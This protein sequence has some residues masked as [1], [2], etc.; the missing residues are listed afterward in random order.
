M[1]AIGL[2]AAAFL[3]VG[4]VQV[5]DFVCDDAFISFRY[6]ANLVEHGELVF[7]VGERVEGYSNFL[8]TVAMALLLWLDL[9]PV[10]GSQVAGLA[11]S[12][13][14]LAVTAAFHRRLDRPGSRRTSGWDA[15]APLLL[16]SSSAFA[17]WTSGGLETALFTL[18]LTLASMTLWAARHDGE[19]R[20]AGWGGVWAG[21]AA[22][23]RPEGVLFAAAATLWSLIG[24][25]RG[26]DRE[27]S[28]AASLRFIAAFGAVYAPYFVWRWIY[29]GWFFPN[30]FYAKSS[31]LELW[32]PGAL[33]V[34]DFLVQSQHLVVLMAIGAWLRPIDDRRDARITGFALIVT[35]A[36]AL[37]VARV[38]GDF[39]AL[40]RYLVPLLPLLALAAVRGA[41]ALSRRVLA[42]RSPR[43][44]LL[45]RSAAAVFAAALLAQAVFVARDTLVPRIEFGI[46][47]V[48]LLRRYSDQWTLA[49]RWFADHAPADASLAITAAGAIPYY[50]GLTTIDILGLTDEWIAH[51]VPPSIPRAGHTRQ[52]PDAYLL[53]RGVDYLVYHP[54][55]A[56]TP[57]K[58]VRRRW[59]DMGFRWRT[60]ALSDQ[61][62]LWI[63]FWE[64][65]SLGDRN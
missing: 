55:I 30:T 24:A 64:Q 10:P 61:P 57:P 45:L 18:L 50:S 13:G 41:R 21:L 11:A 59:G 2:V 8:W 33:Y 19:T 9:D 4:H 58:P 36:F 22:L 29:Y 49:G 53:E 46:D 26:P 37:H 17:C 52:A 5:F 1:R 65:E 39:M 56:E 38:G 48:G 12:L 20:A 3:L 25:R 40:H 42:A 47:S 32:W 62:P 27:A 7:N 60:V 6:A 15:L 16:A 35:L 51:S 54:N 28:N 31:G 34:L 23:A 63:G 43:A 14:T 44:P